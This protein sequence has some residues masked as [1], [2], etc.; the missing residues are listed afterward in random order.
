MPAIMILQ[1]RHRVMGWILPRLS[2]RSEIELSG[3]FS[4]K[5]FFELFSKFHVVFMV[6]MENFN[7]VTGKLFPL[8][9]AHLLGSGIMI[10]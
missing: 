1:Q 9:A 3:L 5:G 10:P 8:I 6:H 4:I 2:L 7:R